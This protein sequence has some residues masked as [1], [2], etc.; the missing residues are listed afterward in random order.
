MFSVK[1]EYEQVMF[2]RSN[3]NKCDEL[4]PVFWLNNELFGGLS[5]GDDDVCVCVWGAGGW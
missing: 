1:M 2:N 4:F 5:G 3:I